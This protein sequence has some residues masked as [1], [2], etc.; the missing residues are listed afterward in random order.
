[1]TVTEPVDAATN[2]RQS[3]GNLLIVG[4]NYAPE[5][6]GIA[7]YTTAVAEHFAAQD[8]HVEVLTGLPCYPEW[9]VPAQYRHGLRFNERRN[10][11][12]VRRLKHA[13]PTQQDA[14]RRGAYE[15][16]FLTQAASCTPARRPDVVLGITPALGGAVAAAFIARRYNARLVLLVQDLLGRAAEQS[17]ISGGARVASTVAKMESFALRRADAVAVVAE[18]FRPQVAALGVPDHRIHLVPNWTHIGES[19]ADRSATRESLGWADGVT[20]A[21]HTGNMGLKQDLGNIVEAARLTRDR[22]DLLWVLMG[23]GSQRASLEQQAAGLPNL[24]FLP[25][26]DAERYRDILAAADVLLLNERDGVAE[27]S[28][29]SKLTSYFASG[30]PVAAAVV[31]NGASAHELRRAGAPAPAPPNEPAALVGL[32]Q[33]VRHS[34]DAGASYAADARRY[35][36]TD[37]GSEASM[38]RL[39]ALLVR[40]RSTPQQR[41]PHQLT[42]NE[43]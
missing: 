42:V 27:M 31:P 37:L 29:P 4:I 30:R 2:L 26:C 32:V 14:L 11:V 22:A 3:I 36:Q 16:T 5:P 34:D 18:A 9:R 38:Q 25:L 35:A 7:P 15:V 20:V 41:T 17:G 43:E 28:L 13:V 23:Q 6:T 39:G 24:R 21:L 10:D 12:S 19:T 8:V 40:G 1:M 33:Q